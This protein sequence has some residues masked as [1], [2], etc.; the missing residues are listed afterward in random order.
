MHNPDED[1]QKADK[2]PEEMSK[3][4]AALEGPYSYS[5]DLADALVAAPGKE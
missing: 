3:V 4:L 2:L 1:F 5:L